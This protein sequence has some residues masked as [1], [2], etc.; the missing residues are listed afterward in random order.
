MLYLSTITE[1]VFEMFVKYLSVSLPKCS[2]LIGS[3]VFGL[4]RASLRGRSLCP[5]SRP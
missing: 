5:I 3:R 2:W 4:T 1:N